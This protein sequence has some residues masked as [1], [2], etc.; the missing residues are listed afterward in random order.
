M[1]INSEFF[2]LLL[3]RFNKYF[4]IKQ[5]FLCMDF[6]RPI[7]VLFHDE[8]DKGAIV[9]Q[10]EVQIDFGQSTLEIHN[11]LQI[12]LAG[13][14]HLS[15]YGSY[16]IRCTNGDAHRAISESQFLDPDYDYDIGYYITEKERNQRPLRISEE[17]K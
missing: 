12:S 11:Y 13:R 14:C 5:L 4:I 2:A 6:T 7:T 9:D 3:E 15:A 17:R 1:A 16:L 8:A 10:L